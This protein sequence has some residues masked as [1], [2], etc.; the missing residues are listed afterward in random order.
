MRVEADNVEVDAIEGASGTFDGVGSG[1]GT[2]A[3][4]RGV[5]KP[6]GTA[7]KSFESTAHLPPQIEV[8]GGPAVTSASG[9]PSF[10]RMVSDQS[11]LAAQAD[12][13]N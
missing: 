5:S 7:S 3:M 6:Q 12:A 11:A 4:L 10:A 13:H 9:R 2:T 8:T 1:L